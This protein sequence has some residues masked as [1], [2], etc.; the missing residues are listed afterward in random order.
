MSRQWSS[1]EIEALK[2]IYPQ[3]LLGKVSVDEMVSIFKRT[4][5][6]LQT[7]AYS[8]HIPTSTYCMDDKIYKNI[9]KK[10]KI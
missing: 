10:L 6:A 1:K 4:P 5:G 2:K 8:L 7:K 9:C 3:Y